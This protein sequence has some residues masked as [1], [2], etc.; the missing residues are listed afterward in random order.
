MVATCAK[1]GLLSKPVVIQKMISRYFMASPP[2]FYC[3][4]QGVYER[5]LRDGSYI[6][7][8]RFLPSS[9]LAVIMETCVSL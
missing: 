8:R 9:G 1:V 5:Q 3:L 2:S 6:G 7:P 4:L